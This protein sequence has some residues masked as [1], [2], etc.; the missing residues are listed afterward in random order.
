VKK[1]EFDYRLTHNKQ[2]LN[3]LETSCNRVE[4]LI[5]GVVKKVSFSMVERGLLKKVSFSSLEKSVVKKYISAWL[6]C[7]KET[8]T[9]KTSQI[10]VKKLSKKLS[11]LVKFIKS[12][13]NWV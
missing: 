4:G 8:K 6:D 3:S 11:K 1:I 9:P 13:E 12:F 5:G 7:Q 10:V 2:E